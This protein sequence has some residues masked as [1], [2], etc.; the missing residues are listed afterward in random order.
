MAEI[1]IWIVALA[2]L[3]PEETLWHPIRIELV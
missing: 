2:I 1:T 3:Q